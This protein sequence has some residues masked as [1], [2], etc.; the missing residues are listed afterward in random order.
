[1][2][3][4]L[5]NAGATYQQLITQVFKH[6]LG[7]NMEA[8]VDDMIV[9]SKQ[10]H[11]HLRDLGETFDRLQFFEMRLN[12]TKCIFGASSG[13][14]LGYLMSQHG[15]EANPDKV[16]AIMDMQPPTTIKEIQK[17][18]GRVAALGRFL[19]RSADKCYEFFKILKNPEQ[20]AWSDQCQ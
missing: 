15:I 7:R 1:M 2:P 3:F 16:W 11:D 5:K 8:Y 12:P 13:K 4:G 18:A 6:Q 17:L 9:K 19:P 10:P 20:F 14:F